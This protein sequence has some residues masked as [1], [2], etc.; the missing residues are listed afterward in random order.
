MWK[1]VMSRIHENLEYKSF[2]MANG[3]VTASVCSKSGRLPIAGV[4]DGCIKTEYFAE[5]TVPTE[6]CDAHYFSNICQYSGLTAAEECPFK[7]ASVIE[8]VP[9]RLQDSNLA[10]ALTALP[11]TQTVQNTQMCPHNSIFFAAPNAQEVLQQQVL[12][13]QQRAAAAA[14]AAAPPP[15]AAPASDTD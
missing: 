8:Q 3:I 12:E 10:T 6:Y 13:M 11:E 7:Q 15:P 4:C 14:A 2:P 1:K 5:G 9:T